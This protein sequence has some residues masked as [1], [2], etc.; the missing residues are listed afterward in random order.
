MLQEIIPTIVK[1]LQG[2]GDSPPQ[3]RDYGCL[4]DLNFLTEITATK[5]FEY[6]AA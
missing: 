5:F 6:G 1:F 4:L 2:T 3:F